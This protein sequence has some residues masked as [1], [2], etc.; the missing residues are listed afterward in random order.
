MKSYVINLK[1]RPERLELFKDRYDNFGPGAKLPLEVVTAID[2]QDLEDDNIGF[3]L[4][5]YNSNK[6][7]TACTLSHIKVWKDIVKTGLCGLVFEDD[8]IFREDGLCYRKWYEFENNILDVLRNHENSIIYIGAGDILPIHTNIVD[9]NGHIKAQS[10]FRAQEKSHVTKLINENVGTPNCRSSY[11]FNWYG[12]F[13]YCISP[14]TAEFLLQ[15]MENGIHTAVDVFLK[16]HLKQ[17]IVVPLLAY[18][19]H[20]STAQSDINIQN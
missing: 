18:H 1:R 2:C 6:G 16:N 4:N 17:Y 7:I 15:T 13:A 5:D 3:E 11:I 19:P 20:L 9:N 8:I 10:L 12:S 14:K